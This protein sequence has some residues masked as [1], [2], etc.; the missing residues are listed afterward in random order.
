MIFNII[1][2][3]FFCIITNNISFLKIL[4]CH[5]D[6]KSVVV[7]YNIELIKISET[8]FIFLNKIKH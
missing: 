2:Q 4:K 7:Y 1:L 5:F 6:V 8:K 3:Y